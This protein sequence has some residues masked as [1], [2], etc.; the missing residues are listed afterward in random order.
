M[1]S[2]KSKLPH[3][4]QAYLTIVANLCLKFQKPIL[5]FIAYKFFFISYLLTLY[6]G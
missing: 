2:I 6:F 3:Y 5:I 1:T 4:K